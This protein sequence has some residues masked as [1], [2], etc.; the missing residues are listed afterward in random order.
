[1]PNFGELRQCEV[2]R[3]PLPRTPLNRV[4]GKKRRIAWR[5][6]IDQRQDAHQRGGDAST[7]AGELVRHLVVEL[8]PAEELAPVLAGEGSRSLPLEGQLQQYAEWDLVSHTFALRDDDSAVVALVL[9]QKAR[10]AN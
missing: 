3:I 4:A 1:M 5:G 8:I 2:R 10:R 6:I 7:M 9:E